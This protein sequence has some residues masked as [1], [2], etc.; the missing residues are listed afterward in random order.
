VHSVIRDFEGLTEL[1]VQKFTG[2][3]ADPRAYVSP[4]KRNNASS[5]EAVFAGNKFHLLVPT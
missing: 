4:P 1:G 2:V 5:R 3:K